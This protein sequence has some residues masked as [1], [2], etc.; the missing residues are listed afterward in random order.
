MHCP[1]L[2]IIRIRRAGRE[3]AARVG[4]HSCVILA[5]WGSVRP[6]ISGLKFEGPPLERTTGD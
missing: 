4:Y 2:P 1:V 3:R 6:G 5:R